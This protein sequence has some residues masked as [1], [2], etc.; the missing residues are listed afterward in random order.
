MSKWIMIYDKCY[1]ELIQEIRNVRVE[2]YT[3]KEFSRELGITQKTVSHYE[4]CRSEINLKLLLKICKILDISFM[5]MMKNFLKQN[6]N[7][8]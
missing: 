7:E 1:Q 5:K 6:D 2:K 4:N 8:I 3:Q